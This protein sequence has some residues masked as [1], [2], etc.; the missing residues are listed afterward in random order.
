MPPDFAEVFEVIHASKFGADL[1]AIAEA[2][3]RFAQQ[4]DSFK[5]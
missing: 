5:A 1:N 3:L 2:W 4:D